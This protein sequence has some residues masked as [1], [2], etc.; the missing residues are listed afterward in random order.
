MKC[1]TIVGVCVLFANLPAAGQDLQYRMTIRSDIAGMD[2]VNMPSP[3]MTMYHSGSK[4]RIESEVP[5]PT[6]NSSGM[7]DYMKVIAIVDRAAGKMFVLN[8]TEKEYE[9]QPFSMPQPDSAQLN[10]F[11]Q[12]QPQLQETGDTLTIN[13]YKTRRHLMSLE[14][15]F[16][17][18]EMPDSQ[19]PGRV[20]MAIENWTAAD[21]VL[22]EAYR[23]LLASMPA[24]TG[25]SP[26]AGVLNQFAASGFPL[27]STMLM[28]SLPDSGTY[29]VDKIL[30][31]GAA[32]EGARMRVVTELN[33]IKIVKLD[34]ALFVVPAD[35][36]RR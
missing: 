14:L 27:R 13:G 22:A 36:R 25:G 24:L 12:S 16:N 7:P 20:L 6:P 31:A 8:E 19:Q 15:P 30:K 2:S 21:P 4:M 3:S 23:T 28:V 35:Y 33:D 29:D 17:P 5:M 26:N 1:A 32:A 34:P 10:S 11:A 18:M 9:E